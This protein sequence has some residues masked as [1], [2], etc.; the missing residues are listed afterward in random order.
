MVFVVKRIWT[1]LGAFLFITNILWSLTLCMDS[2][3]VPKR[4]S[5]SHILYWVTL[6]VMLS[7]LF[8]MI[9]GTILVE[10]ICPSGPPICST[11]LVEQICPSGGC[12][13]H[14]QEAC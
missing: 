1:T 6:T 5:D 14:K 8:G 2:I 3:S 4:D 10:Q 12:E 9:I 7:T 11:I 13:L